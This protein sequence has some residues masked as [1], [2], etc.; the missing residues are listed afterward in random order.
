MT[1]YNAIIV[2]DEFNVQQA[3][4]ILVERFCPEINICGKAASA[5]AARLL[6]NQHDV[7]LIFLD[8]SMPGENGF[9]FL[10]SIPKEK[11]AI[12][13]TTAYEEYALRAIKANAIDYLLK[14]IDHNE[15]REAV[16]KATSYLDLRKE[17][18]ELQRTYNESLKNLS[19]QTSAGIEYPKKVTVSEKFG[20]QIVEVSKIRYLEADQ[21]YCI[22]HLSGLEKIISSRSLGEFEK[23][24]DPATFFRIHKSTIINMNYLTGFSSY[25]GSYAVLD[26][27]TKLPISRRRANDFKEAVGNFSKTLD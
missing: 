24:L 25:E 7:Q 26:E 20:F 6:L 18:I 11:Y 12:I 19:E 3:L 16:A 23:I 22:L 10:S 1:S 21:N 17:S 27:N 5:A 8:I 15:L 13:F 9:E 2:D 4:G 14:P